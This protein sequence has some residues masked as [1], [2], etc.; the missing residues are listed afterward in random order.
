RCL[1]QGDTKIGSGT[2]RAHDISRLNQRLGGNTAEVDAGTAEGV[3]LVADQRDG[4]A[5]LHGGIGCGQAGTAADYDDI[6]M[7]RCGHGVPPCCYGKSS[8][9]CQVENRLTAF[10]WQRVPDRCVQT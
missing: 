8:S 10:V 9:W 5:G 1:I 4:A 3:G 2:H 6:E 7:L